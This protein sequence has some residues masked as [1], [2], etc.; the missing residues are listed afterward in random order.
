MPSSAKTLRVSF[1]QCRGTPY[2]A[3]RAQA[4]AF[5]VT[6]KGKALLRC[7]NVMLQQV[8]SY[9]GYTGRIS[10]TFGKAAHD[11]KATFQIL[12]Q[13]LRFSSCGQLRMLRSS[14]AASPF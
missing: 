4:D 7:R 14:W 11:P 13:L 2:E 9:L 12:R 8:G 6:R 1:V 5:A 3:G 10:N